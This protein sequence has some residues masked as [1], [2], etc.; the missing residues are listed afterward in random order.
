M[1]RD[2]EGSVNVDEDD[3][4]TMGTPMDVDEPGA[5]GRSPSV[6]SQVTQ[7]WTGRRVTRGPQKKAGKPVLPKH[8]SESVDEEGR[9][10]GSREGLGSFLPMSDVSRTMVALKL[11]GSHSPFICFCSIYSSA[12]QG[13]GTR[14]RNV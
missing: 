9:L 11:K 12:A 10:P 1:E 7:L 4:L 3:D 13:N 14:R 5:N 8:V 2:E 6:G